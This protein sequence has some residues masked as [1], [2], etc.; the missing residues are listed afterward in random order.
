MSEERPPSKYHVPELTQEDVPD[1]ACCVDETTFATLFPNYLESYIKS[2]WPAVEEL[3]AQHQLVGQLDLMEGSMTVA[4]TRRTWDPYVIVNARD[5]IKL[6]ARNVPLAQAQKIFSLGIVSDIINIGIKGGSTR[7]FVKRRDR[8]IG[9]KAQT[10]KALEILTGCYVLVQGK[11][12]SVMGPVKGTQMV[13]KVVEDCM[14]N[15][16]PIYGLK[17]LLIKR[18]LG[19]REDMKNQDWSRFIPVYKKSLPN[20]EKQKAVRKIKKERLK[21]AKAK[22][23]G[24][25]KSIFP[26]APSK[27]L[28]DIAME[29]GKAFLTEKKRRPRDD[30][31]LST[32][33]AAGKGKGKADKKRTRKE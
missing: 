24:K 18:E 27:R 26:P 10:L 7:R 4:T 15:I 28:E 23:A 1:G 29:S 19:K 14:N 30:F 16:H 13:R 9:P 3:L 17:Q 33:D 32:P 20:K 5:F 6:L 25:V 21:N 8:L 11:T 2:I 22:T 12:V 31:E